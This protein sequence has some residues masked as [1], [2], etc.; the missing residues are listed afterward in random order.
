M[1][2][3]VRIGVLA[4]IAFS[5]LAFVGGQPPQ[6]KDKD[7]QSAFEPRSSPGVGQKYL[8]R[9]VGQWTVV[10]KFFPRKGDPV[11]SKGECIQ[12]II[13]EGR[14][15]QSNFIFFGEAGKTTGQGIIG[16]ETQTGLFTSVWTDSR[17]TRMSFR[18]SKDAFDGKQIVLYGKTFADADKP[19]TLSKTVSRLD[20]SGN[21]LVH[22][23]VTIEQGGQERPVME[24]VLT[25]KPK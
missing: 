13:H 17:A 22:R 1:A 24:L 3:S 4:V 14:F 8:E 10:K 7:P 2:F 12:T 21:T 23:Q 18:Q 19:A 11:E 6:K 5:G 20:E 16:F 15:L 25:R 9:F